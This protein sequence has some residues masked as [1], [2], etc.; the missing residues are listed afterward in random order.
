MSWEIGEQIQRKSQFSKINQEILAKSGFLEEAEAKVLL[1][2]FLRE[3]ISFATSLISGVDLFP[4]QHMAIKSMFES[5][6][7]LGVW[8]SEEHTSELQSQD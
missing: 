4:F 8:R 7:F 5:D 1:Y 2:K 6:Y 3:N